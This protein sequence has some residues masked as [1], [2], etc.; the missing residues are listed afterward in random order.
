MTR[1]SGKAVITVSYTNTLTEGRRLPAFS[2]EDTI[3]STPDTT[4]GKRG[5]VR[6]SKAF[7]NKIVQKK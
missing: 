5:R 2:T 4:P 3:S 1:E 6:Y 7:K